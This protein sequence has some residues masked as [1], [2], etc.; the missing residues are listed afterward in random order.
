MSAALSVWSGRTAHVRRK[1]FKR[2]FS[3]PVSLIEI[4]IDLAAEATN[5]SIW[6]SVNK[7]NL[8]SWWNKDYGPQTDD[9][10]LR[11]WAEKRLSEAGLR[12]RPHSV[13]LLTFPRLLGYGFSPLSIWLALD[14]GE[15]LMGV[16]YEVHNT[17]GEAH[18][19]V[20]N[21]QDEI[22]PN[23]PAVHESKKSFHVSPF[24]DVSG[25]Y[26]FKLNFSAQTLKLVIENKAEDGR[27]HTAS[28][29]ARRQEYTAKALTRLVFFKPFAALGVTAAIHWEALWI[30]L[31]GAG[32]RSRPNLP[33]NQSTI[34]KMNNKRSHDKNDLT[35][36]ETIQ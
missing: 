12:T 1:P 26:R 4:D 30:W 10:S 2:S 19:Y 35:T 24:M 8:A 31:K 11:D 34:A 14:A 36:R 18:A 3:Y 20:A 17:F 28:L 32:Y 9:A 22:A 6:F 13:R 16:I 29:S 21:F 5:A 33:H 25:N 27:W 15:E 7:F 23:T